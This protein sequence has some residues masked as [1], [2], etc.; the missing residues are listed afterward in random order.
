MFH[1]LKKEK[2]TLFDYN[3][4]LPFFMLRIENIPGNTSN[5]EY[6]VT[7][8]T[9]KREKGSKNCLIGSQ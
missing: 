3:N 8:Y 7:T 6:H 4:P 1:F 2:K 5:Y 9:Y